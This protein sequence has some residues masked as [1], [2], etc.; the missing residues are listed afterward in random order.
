MKRSKRCAWCGRSDD[1]VKSVTVDVVGALGIKKQS[2]EVGVHAEHQ[3]ELLR[4]IRYLNKHTVHFIAL[5]VGLTILAIVA[6]I[7]LE[8]GGYAA[9]WIF[10]LIVMA[11]GIV[12]LVFPFA[13]ATSASIMSIRTSRRLVRD[14]GVLIMIIGALLSIFTI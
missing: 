5:N 12:L 14:S 4:Y 9:W 3:S 2:V 1:T 7:V 10:G 6:I 8:V 11:Y 13:T